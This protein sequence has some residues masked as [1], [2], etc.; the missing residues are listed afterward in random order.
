MK[1][2]IKCAF[3]CLAATSF[4]AF[5]PVIV[6]AQ[7]PVAVHN[8]DP[9]PADGSSPANAP[10]LATNGSLYGVTPPAGLEQEGMLYKISSNGVETILHIFDS[11]NYLANTQDG[12]VPSG[13]L[14]EVN[15]AIYGTTLSGGSFGAGAMFKVDLSK[16]D[17]YT[18]VHDFSYNDGYGCLGGLTVDG[19]LIYGTTVNNGANNGNGTIFTYDTSLNS[20]H[21]VYTFKSASGVVNPTGNLLKVGSFFYGVAASSVP[22]FNGAVFKFDPVSAQ[23]V[24]YYNFVGGTTDGQQ[25]NGRMAVSGNFIYGT[26]QYGGP[27]NEGTVF[28][29]DPTQF[30]TGGIIESDVFNFASGSLHTSPSSPIGGLTASG[31]LLYGT[32]RRGGTLMG[33]TI[34]S[35]NPGGNTLNLQFGFSSAPNSA[36]GNYPTSALFLAPDNTLYGVTGAGD[37]Y[38]TQFGVVYHF[39]PSTNGENVVHNFNDFPADGVSPMPA[40]IQAS[41]GML[42]GI[43][44][45]GGTY[46]QG[47]IYKVDPATTNETVVYNFHEVPGPAYPKGPL[48]EY[49]GALYGVTSNGGPLANGT[50]YKLTL[51]GYN[52]STIYSFKYDQG[53]KDTTQ[54]DGAQPVGGLTVVGNMLF[55]NTLA[56]GPGTITNGGTDPHY[57]VGTIFSINPATGVES[58]VRSFVSTN[59]PSDIFEPQG[60]MLFSGGKLYGTTAYGTS[61]S[62][63]VDSLFQYDPASSSFQILYRFQGGLPGSVDGFAPNPQLVLMNGYIYGTTMFGGTSQSWASVGVGKAGGGTFYRVNVASQKEDYVYSFGD[64]SAVTSPTTDS[65]MPQLGLFEGADGLLYGSTYLGGSL[66]HGTLFSF[67]P[68]KI[69]T[70]GFSD[71]RLFNFD[72]NAG[73][74]YPQDLMLAQ[75][76]S[77]YF[78]M[79]A[80]GT[81]QWGSLAKFPLTPEVVQTANYLLVKHGFVMNH[82]THQFMQLVTVTNTG[83]LPIPGNV[84]LIVTGLNFG[85]SLAHITG[86]TTN[87]LPGSPYI[88]LVQNGLKPGSSASIVLTYNDPAGHPITPTFTLAAG[89]GAP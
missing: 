53:A 89:A 4:S 11:A 58:P 20:F 28:C 7:T 52:F 3:V 85:V 88:T 86:T 82:F 41:D 84:S 12:M 80:A 70:P 24:G 76:G 1:S 45:K 47:T 27:T 31:N 78:S 46:N 59:S 61:A 67:D 56:G 63:P 71:T 69:G 87:V 77:L 73:I 26:T 51:S 17:A 30:G 42:Y 33:G 60:D 22:K 21:V 44:E 9:R 64:P 38:S 65:A 2:V 54:F 39:N 14:V 29:I 8:F 35:F 23:I 40:L 74:F 57:S 36:T 68:S 15:N 19:S 16:N 48:V 25:P 55:G 13:R 10:I 66:G 75:D 83:S 43:T 37:P 34:F 49:N 72:F 79:A 18:I 32:T 62:A 50:V 81:F 5:S 6:G